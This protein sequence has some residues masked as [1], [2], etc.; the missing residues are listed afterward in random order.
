[1]K[2]ATSE[3]TP[4]GWTVSNYWGSVQRWPFLFLQELPYRTYPDPAPGPSGSPRTIQ[5]TTMMVP[6]ISSQTE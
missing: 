2:K 1:M 3:L 6:T 5:T 4:N